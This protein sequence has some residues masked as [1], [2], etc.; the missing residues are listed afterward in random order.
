M[1]VLSLFLMLLGC[2]YNGY[3]KSKPSVK[4]LSDALQHHH[5]SLRELDLDVDLNGRRE[6]L[7]EI[8]YRASKYSYH[9]V[10]K[11]AVNEIKSLHDALESRALNPKRYVGKG[12]DTTERVDGSY[13]KPDHER[14]IAAGY[15]RIA[16]KAAQ[17]REDCDN[18]Y[19][20]DLIYAIEPDADSGL[21]AE[22]RRAVA[23]CVD[24]KH[25]HN[26]DT[27]D[28][29]WDRRYLWK[30]RPTE[31]GIIDMG[32]TDR[33]AKLIAVL[34][35][36]WLR[37]WSSHNG[38]RL[39]AVQINAGRALLATA[40]D[41]SVF[42]VLNRSGD[43]DVRSSLDG[44][45]IRTLET[46]RVPS[47][48]AITADGRYLAIA[49]L[50]AEVWDIREG[51]LVHRISVEGSGPAAL[52]IATKPLKLL[53]SWRNYRKRGAGTPITLCDLR[54][55]TQRTLV[56][57]QGVYSVAIARDASLV[58]LRSQYAITLWDTQQATC[59]GALYRAGN[60][61][62][63]KRF[64][65]SSDAAYLVD[66]HGDVCVWKTDSGMI[67]H[68]LPYGGEAAAMREDGKMVAA[69]G[70]VMVTYEFARTRH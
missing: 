65:F 55:K 57:A 49:A 60:S 30:M 40:Q 19:L 1:V 18:T 26:G 32:F 28:L 27:A 42:A 66:G 21:H 47:D 50:D 8:A 17:E 45:I 33:G 5:S 34:S 39:W 36:D 14:L 9:E 64:R 56:E 2:A 24:S 41:A 15:W 54:N 6:A 31:G 22:W 43:V 44:K 16:R 62:Q 3:R 51:T 13:T 69:G 48:L 37:C 53:V 20:R 23:A 25:N 61:S 35:D 29:K 11:D 63:G 10:A 68:V 38:A 70:D 7:T 4:A 59:R 46:S 67:H 52:D 12:K 58:A